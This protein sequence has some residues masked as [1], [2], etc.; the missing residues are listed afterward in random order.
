MSSS[1]DKNNCDRFR[2][3]LPPQQQLKDTFQSYHGPLYFTIV[4]WSGGH[5]DDRIVIMAQNETWKCC[6][7]NAIKVTVTE[8]EGNLTVL[9][10][11]FP[12]YQTIVPSS[13]PSSTDHV[14]CPPPPKSHSNDIILVF[15]GACGVACNERYCYNPNRPQ[16]NHLLIR[17]P[18][19]RTSI[20]CLP[21]P[22]SNVRHF[23]WVCWQHCLSGHYEHY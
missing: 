6:L 2:W 7:C 14:D 16:S 21:I 12:Y 19:I 5:I 23:A 17:R 13:P 3:R 15:F 1:C 22:P 11:W 4:T 10:Q 8:D 9:I 18:P 20:V